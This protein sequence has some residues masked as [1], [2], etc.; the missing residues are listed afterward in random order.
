MKLDEAI[1]Q[2]KGR[3][4]IYRDALPAAPKTLGQTAMAEFIAEQESLLATIDSLRAQ[5][6]EA[7]IDASR[8]KT[9]FAKTNN[10]ICQVLGKALGYPWHKDHQE[11]FPGSGEAD[12]V[13][14]GEHV[15][16]S[17]ADEIAAKYAEAKRQAIQWHDGPAVGG[18]EMPA[19]DAEVVAVMDF[20]SGARAVKGT[21]DRT[22]LYHDGCWTDL[23]KVVRWCY[24]SD[25]VPAETEKDKVKP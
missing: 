19:V 16:G 20:R 3:I 21:I 1:K 18:V 12:G 8:Y 4:D 6:A 7:Q 25:L 9:A 10:D 24:A 11:A 22:T 23:E 2:A 17:L 14:V 5:L 13:C 15:A